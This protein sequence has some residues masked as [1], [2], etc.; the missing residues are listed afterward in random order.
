MVSSRVINEYAEDI[1]Q[2]FL[3]YRDDDASHCLKHG[4]ELLR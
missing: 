4:D 1:A 2:Q 3:Q